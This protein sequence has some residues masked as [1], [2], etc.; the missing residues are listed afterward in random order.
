MLRN[1]RQIEGRPLRAKDGIIGEVKDV[2][3]DDQ[4]WHVRY[5]VV[6]TGAWLKKRKVLVAAE[7]FHGL[8]W[9][10]QVFPV[11]LTM[12]QVRNS[13][14]I[15]TDKPVSRQHEESLRRYYSWPLYWEPIF[16]AGNAAPI[17]T[18]MPPPGA[19][20]TD[21]NAPLQTRGDPHLRSANDTLKSHLAARDGETGHVDD[22]LVDETF[23]R[24]R[25]L[26]VDTRNWLPGKKVL[27]S[28]DWI[29][30]VSWPNRRVTIDLTREAIK[31]SPPYDPST[32]LNS[33]HAADLHDYYGRPRY[34]DWD[35]DIVA[36][37][38]RTSRGH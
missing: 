16:G 29:Q 13:P 30:D 38:P 37:A 2:Y 15:D 17:L 1:L 3:F 5:L 19:G 34:S 8:D 20:L 28:P 33:A 31:G 22:F 25:Y 10:L 6:E 18:S 27:V 26:V 4:H 21:G 14:S 11:E 9:G 24:I 23:W 12:E 32:P 35:K 36:G 7:V